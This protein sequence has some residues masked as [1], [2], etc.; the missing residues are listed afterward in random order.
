MRVTATVTREGSRYFAQCR[1]VDRAG[2]GATMDEA[3]QSLRDALTEYFDEVPA[4]APP[5]GPSHDPIEIVVVEVPAKI[6][7]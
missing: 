3:I 7:R 2:E 6:E 1:E 5:E 4:V